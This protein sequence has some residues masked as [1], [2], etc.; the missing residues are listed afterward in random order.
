MSIDPGKA[1][2]AELP[3]RHVEWDEADVLLYHLAL[4]AGSRPGDQTDPK[5]L[6]YTTENDLH[7]LPSFGVVTP[8]LRD[9]D[10]PSL[11]L[12]GCDI[13]LAAVLHG[14]QE[15]VVHTPLP[16]RARGTARTRISNV[17]D[18]GKAAVIVQESATRDDSGE[19]LF[20]T[21]SSIFVKG[22]GGFG[23][24]RGPSS[25]VQPPDRATDL[26]TTFA[27]TA[28]QAL[29]YRLCG[30][31][32]PLHSDPAFAELAGYPEPI[33]HGLCSYGIVLRIVVDELLD[34]DVS[35]VAGFN[36]RFAGVVFPGETI[37]VQAWD[38]GERVIVSATIAGG[39]PD[40]DGAPVLA[41][42]VLTKR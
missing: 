29:L 2:G 18:K 7:V 23:G 13:D 19:L 20:T 6:R 26:D 16:T 8:T 42:T 5:A 28:Q 41:D 37:R 14:S 3:E 31:R 21:R 35:V 17:W 24:E 11:E 30:D 10:S 12:P 32:N 9:T 22:E 38:E 40:R 15:I 34:A 27:T 33:L 4:G 39:A 36:A 1:I 25:K